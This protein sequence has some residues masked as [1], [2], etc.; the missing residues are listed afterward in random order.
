MCLVKNFK[1]IAEKT[2]CSTYKDS[3]CF[4]FLKFSC[5]FQHA[6]AGTYHIV[7]YDNILALNALTE[8]LMSN[9]WVSAVYNS[10]VISSLIE[11]TEI[12][13][14]LGCKINTSVHC[15]LVG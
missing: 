1:T 11:H 15:A 13:S 14:E 6:F 2:E 10:G 12:N 3:L 4:E 5:N 8:V 7:N 9:D